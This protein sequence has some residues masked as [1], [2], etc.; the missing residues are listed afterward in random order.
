MTTETKFRGKRVDNGEWVYGWLFR[1]CLTGHLAIQQTTSK[2]MEDTGSL[3][4][5]TISP[6][7]VENTVSQ[8]TGLKSSDGGCELPIVD[9]YFGD[10]IEVYSTEGTRR[11][12][13]IGWS[14]EWQCV[15]LG[16]KEGGLPYRSFY[17][18]GYYQPSKI[19]FQ[20]IGNIIDNPELISI[21]P[22]SEFNRLITKA[23]TPNKRK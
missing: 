10:I 21:D 14:N 9:A 13:Q 23:L 4:I 1:D 6:E 5:R 20:I 8:L 3:S 7:V 11:V 19:Q 15:T 18:S 17:E 2:K 22:L 16:D 12:L